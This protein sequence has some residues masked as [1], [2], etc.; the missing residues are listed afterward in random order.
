M[1]HLK[2]TARLIVVGVMLLAVIA[3]GS[4]ATV[5]QAQP[6]TLVIAVEGSPPTFDPLAAADSRVDTPSINLYNALVQYKPGTTETELELAES[7]TPA[8]DGLSYTFKLRKGVKFHDGTELTAE[9]VKYTIDRMVK[10]SQGVARSLTMVTGAD[11][12]DPS[13]VKINLSEPF[14]GFM[15]AMARV[16]ILNSKLVI[17]NTTNDDWG[18]T[19]LQNHDAGSGPY[20]LVSFQAEQQF[21]IEKFPDYFKGWDGAHVDRAV[22]RVIKEEATRRLALESGEA[23][24]ILVGSPETFDA[25]KAREGIVVNSDVTLN[26][27]YFAM[28]TQNEYL[29]DARVRQAMALVYDYAGHVTQARNG[30]ADI[31]RGPIPSSIPCFDDSIQP[32]ETNIEKAK[33]LM[34]DA[35]Y[36]N[37][38][39]ELTMA[40]QGT[41]PE[42]TAAMQIWQAG[43]AQLGVTIKPLAVEW[44]A[45]VQA[46]SSQETAP[47][48]G[49]IWIFPALPDPDQYVGILGSSA[50]AGGGGFNFSWYSNPKMDELINAGKSELDPAKRC[51][52]YKQI[53]QLW[54]QDVPYANVV[55]GHALS[56]SRDY[57]KGY[58]WSAAHSFTQNVYTMWV[59]K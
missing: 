59:E 37:G 50:Q 26:Q 5:A 17:A 42:E 19:W 30:H 39:F 44:P 12:I 25:L 13:T 47:A 7:V 31:A 24:W 32:S 53:Q 14:P 4:I 28:N 51:D 15:G 38:G 2:R 16:Y 8:D 6:V 29:K 22:F 34:A 41:A 54:I 21:T 45:K 36:P 11:V 23:D 10:L 3:S 1:L 9:D 52:I 35:G 57:V 43:A 27:L 56:A 49:T 20:T 58:Q 48:L 33:Q 55:I 46:F 40:Y 18:Q